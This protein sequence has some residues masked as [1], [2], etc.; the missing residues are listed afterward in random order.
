MKRSE[1]EKIR[2]WRV[3]LDALGL[4]LFLAYWLAAVYV[5][6]DVLDGLVR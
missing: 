3:I 4:A 2:A 1:P 6:A 5:F